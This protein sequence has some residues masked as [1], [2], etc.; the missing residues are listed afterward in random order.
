M[1]TTFISCFSIPFGNIF[2]AK[3]PNN[4]YLEVFH[5]LNILKRKRPEA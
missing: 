2:D 5:P 1:C 4:N 3:V